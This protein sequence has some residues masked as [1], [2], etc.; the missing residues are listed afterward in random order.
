MTFTDQGDQARANP[1][2]RGECG[3]RAVRSRSIPNYSYI[4]LTKF[5]SPLGSFANRGQ[6]AALEE[7]IDAVMLPG[8]GKQMIRV[9]TCPVVTGMAHIISRRDWSNMH[10]IG[11]SVWA[12]KPF[13]PLASLHNTVARVLD[14]A[15]PYPTGFGFMHLRPEPIRDWHR[16]SRSHASVR[17]KDTWRFSKLPRANDER[18]VTMRAYS[19]YFNL[20]VR[21][22]YIIPPMGNTSE[23]GAGVNRDGDGVYRK[24]RNWA[25]LGSKGGFVRLPWA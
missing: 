15:Y 10:L 18:S 16:L 20:L 14:S 9:N 7:G 24:Q 22:A 1:E 2:L 17:A 5:A 25:E 11:K 19:R 4:R 13:A 3:A 21:H 8:A 6:A 12:N 23:E